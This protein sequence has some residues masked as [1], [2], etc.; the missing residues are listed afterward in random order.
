MCVGVF[1][2]TYSSNISIFHFAFH[3]AWSVSQDFIVQVKPEFDE[4]EIP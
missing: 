3:G 1:I 4:E 2:G